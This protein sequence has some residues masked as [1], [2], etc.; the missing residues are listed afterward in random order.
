MIDLKMNIANFNLTYGNKDEPLLT[1][2]EEFIYPAFNEEI[3]R[4][5]SGSKYFL[6]DVKLVYT[7]NGYAL[8]G[9][10]VKDTILEVKSI[11]GEDGEI[12]YTDKKHPSAPYSYFSI[13]LKNHR[14][15]YALNQKG[16]PDLRSFATTIRYILKEY[17]NKYNSLHEEN[18]LPSFNLNVVGVPRKAKILNELKK[19]EKIRTLRIAFYPLNEDIPLNDIIDEEL[20][21]L[22]KNLGSKT[23]N[24]TFNSPQNKEEIAELIEDLGD[25]NKTT[26]EVTYP[27][28]KKGKIRNDNISEQLEI[29]A[30]AN[31]L[32]DASDEILEEANNNESL[33]QVS[34]ANKNLYARFKDMLTNL[35]SE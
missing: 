2:F 16:S 12:E 30:D 19:V 4:S 25:L 14:M 13:F 29:T 3:V 11:I 15:I 18:K 22:R 7:K 34:D 20:V 9:I 35:A 31:N 6:K 27:D 21:R 1:Y 17:R 33:N 5:K 8:T 26:L 10:I 32:A 28:G 24:V 23:G